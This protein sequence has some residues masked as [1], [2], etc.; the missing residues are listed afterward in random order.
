MILVLVAILLIAS[1]DYALGNKFS[2]AISECIGHICGK[3]YNKKETTDF[4]TRPKFFGE[5][6]YL[7]MQ[8]FT[9]NAPSFNIQI[10]F[11]DFVNILKMVG[12]NN[13]R[14]IVDWKSGFKLIVRGQTLDL[15][16]FCEIG[17]VKTVVFLIGETQFTLS[18]NCDTG[19]TFIKTNSK[20]F[21][22]EIVTLVFKAESIQTPKNYYGKATLELTRMTQ[23]KLEESENNKIGDDNV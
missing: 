12:L 23:K 17:H 10:P 2:D 13:E 20:D 3:L 1:I 14:W 21:E 4:F 18:V 7:P 8:G 9:V 19:D 11:N 5:K 16:N 15:T 22:T 6:E